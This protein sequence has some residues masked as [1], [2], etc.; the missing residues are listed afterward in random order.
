MKAVARINTTGNDPVRQR[1]SHP[2]LRGGA[3][4]RAQWDGDGRMTS[5]GGMAYFAEYLRDSGFLELLLHGSPLRYSS[6]N[7]PD[8][9]DVMG[10]C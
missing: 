5:L 4:I 7:A 9:A 10:R 8:P 3:S 1:F 2:M 6:P